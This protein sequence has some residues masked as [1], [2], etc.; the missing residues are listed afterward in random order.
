MYN[1]K[2]IDH[3]SN[4][5]NMGELKEFDV[6]AEGGNPAC[7]D[8]VRLWIKLDSNK[9]KISD[10]KFKAFGCGACIAS[11]SAMS[12]MTEG[13]TVGYALKLTR[14]DISKY[15]DGLPEQKKKCSNFS[16]EV[17]QKALKDAV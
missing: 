2:T 6:K 16:T 13:K 15:L 9:K 12:E 1:Q 8:V 14:E 10:I 3:F 7:G 11:A 5:R 17:L 4:P